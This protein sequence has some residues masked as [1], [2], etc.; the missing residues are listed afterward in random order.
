MAPY[1]S[2]CASFPNEMLPCGM[3][4]TGCSPAALAYAAIEAEVF[5][6]ETQATRVIPSRT[7][8]DAPQVIPLSLND[9]VGLKPWCLKTSASSP[10]YSAASAPR[11]QRRAAFAQRHHA[12]VVVQER[13][14][15]A[16]A[17]DAAL[18]QR[19]VGH[20]ALA[21]QGLQLTGGLRRLA[22]HRFQQTA[23]LR[24]IVEHFGDG[25]TARGTALRYRQVPQA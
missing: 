10:P 2:A 21:P 14:E 25:D 12:R 18:V 19:R 15:L 7:A 6:V 20:A 23:A 4:I 16:V 5:P 1:S 11:Q 17:P 9:P 22:V 24:A 3:K 13:D 8:C